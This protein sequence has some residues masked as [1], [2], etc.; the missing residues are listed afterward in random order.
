MKK[1]WKGKSV[2][3]KYRKRERA[4]IYAYVCVCVCYCCLSGKSLNHWIYHILKLGNIEY[5]SYR[6]ILYLILYVKQCI[7]YKYKISSK[8][9]VKWWWWW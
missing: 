9:V 7:L 2:R 3:N 5:R 6:N 4:T 1:K 8:V